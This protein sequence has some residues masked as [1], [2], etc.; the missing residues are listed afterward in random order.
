MG[1]LRRQC[2]RTFGIDP[3]CSCKEGA[4][5][6]QFSKVKEIGQLRCMV[7]TPAFMVL[8]FLRQRQLHWG[9]G[10]GKPY[11]WIELLIHRIYFLESR[12]SCGAR[13]F[14]VPLCSIYA[15]SIYVYVSHYP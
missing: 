13:F 9:S 6:T 10:A 7:L 11:Y 1:Y 14:F 12:L 3:Q 15:S 5:G 4:L 8:F 2:V